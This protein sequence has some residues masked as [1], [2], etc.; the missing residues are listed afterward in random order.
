MCFCGEISWELS[1]KNATKQSVWSCDE[2]QSEVTTGKQ[3]NVYFSS[4]FITL[5]GS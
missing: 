2:I 5:T 1:K 3:A 4:M